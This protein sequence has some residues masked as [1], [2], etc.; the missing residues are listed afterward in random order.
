MFGCNQDITVWRREKDSDT[1]KEIFTK[2]DIP[3]KCMWKSRHE[4]HINGA[5]ANLS[6]RTVVIIPYFE[7]LR[8]ISIKPGDRIECAGENRYEKVTVSAVKYNF[9][10]NMRGGHVRAEGR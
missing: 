3:V 8:G 9:G 5:G 6:E 2:V 1:K 10:D 4:S 7:G